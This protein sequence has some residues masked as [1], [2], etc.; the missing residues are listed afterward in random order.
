MLDS[1]SFNR[2]TTILPRQQTGTTSFSRQWTRD[3]QHKGCMIFC[4]DFGYFQHRMQMMT[5]INE[6]EWMIMNSFL[7][8]FHL[9]CQFYTTASLVEKNDNYHSLPSLSTCNLVECL[10][11]CYM[12]G[13][14]ERMMRREKGTFFFISLVYQKLIPILSYVSLDSLLSF[15]CRH[16]E[17]Q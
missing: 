12:K 5:I 3:R 8:R 1:S 4:T 6:R 17:T 13:L 16:G 11:G 7:P 10:S 15:A 14:E 2:Y 9:S